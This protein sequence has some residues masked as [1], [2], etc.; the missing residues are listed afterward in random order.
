MQIFP[1]VFFASSMS[2]TILTAYFS[3]C[4]RV[5]VRQPSDAAEM[6]YL[7]FNKTSVI[8]S[9]SSYTGVITSKLIA[10]SSHAE[11]EYYYLPVDQSIRHHFTLG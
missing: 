2:L 7:Y 5:E 3:V 6:H 4:P 9:A 10:V 8:Q 1:S 11:F